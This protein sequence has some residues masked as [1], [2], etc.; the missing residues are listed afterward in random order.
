MSWQKGK[1]KLLNSQ[2]LGMKDKDK[3][4]ERKREREKENKRIE[5]KSLEP[6]HY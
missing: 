5:D 6:K 2:H 3:D 4:R 1:G